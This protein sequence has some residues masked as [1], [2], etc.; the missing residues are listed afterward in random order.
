MWTG[1]NTTS[2][3]KRKCKTKENRRNRDYIVTFMK[4]IVDMSYAVC[5]TSII[6]IVLHDIIFYWIP[7]ETSLAS[8]LFWSCTALRN[9][10]HNIH[11]VLNGIHRNKFSM[12]RVPHD[13]FVNRHFTSE[14]KFCK[15]AE[16]RE[17][18]CKC[19]NIWSRLHFL[20]KY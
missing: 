15:Y 10:K 8:L 19:T 14:S 6:C 11:Y 1:V 13:L 20:T 16:W 9:H 18:K 7:I 2:K 3:K 4:Y 12:H 5:I 17:L